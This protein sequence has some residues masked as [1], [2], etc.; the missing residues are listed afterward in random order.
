[1]TRS[2]GRGGRRWRTVRAEILRISDVC[3]IC[4][5]PGAGDVDHDPIPLREVELLGLDPCD[6]A[7]LKPAHGAL[8]RCPT[9]GKNCNGLKGART[10]FVLNPSSRAW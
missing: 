7:N 3:H 4:A 8:S 1:M 2:L 9:C 10:D 6:P 5:H